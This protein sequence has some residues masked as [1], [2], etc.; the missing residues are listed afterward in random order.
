MIFSKDLLIKNNIID[1]KYQM[2]VNNILA[3]IFLAAIVNK[4]VSIS[5][6][7]NYYSKIPRFHRPEYFS[8][9]KTISALDYLIDSGYV[10]QTLGYYDRVNGKT[11]R[12][13]RIKL[14]DKFT[15]MVV[16][17]PEIMFKQKII[18]PLI[19][20]GK[21][22]RDGVKPL[23]P[24]QH[25]EQTKKMLTFLNEFNEFMSSHS[26]TLKDFFPAFLEG[27]SQRLYIHKNMLQREAHT[28]AGGSAEAGTDPLLITNENTEQ[29]CTF[30]VNYYR[31]FNNGN[32]NEGGRFYT[33]IQ[34]IKKQLRKKIMIDNKPT[35]EAD[36]K[37][38]HIRMLYH[39]EGIEYEGDP[40]IKIE[41]F[42]RKE[43]KQL[44][45]ILLN[46]KDKSDAL[47]AGIK[48][49]KRKSKYI[50][51]ALAKI[52]N[53]HSR[54]S[55]YFCSGVGIYLQYYDSEI[56]EK[57]FRYF[58][59]NGIGIIGVHDS[60]ITAKDY[61]SALIEVMQNYYKEHF[62]YNPTITIN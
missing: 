42:K 32:F 5:R 34:N 30:D 7:S 25:T 3:N 44:C 23:I 45:Q 26:V 9:R 61:E 43:V 14:T 12:V 57:V 51:Q 10:R 40:Y 13:T 49:L 53:E 18:N 33:A 50:K 16:T 2:S 46:A 59:E 47:K 22:Q 54:I 8:Y 39:L 19:L 58:Y 27:S 31:V 60:F 24:Y 62:N 6:R 41:G 56:T 48:Y 4:S 36:Y 29:K 21:K 37:A 15:D 1:F 38:L 52:E 11:N 55:K 20:K 35:I 17:I 28:G